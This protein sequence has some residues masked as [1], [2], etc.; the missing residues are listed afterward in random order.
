[1]V[2]LQEERA[3]HAEH[4]KHMAFPPDWREAALR[5]SGPDA[6]TVNGPKMEKREG[7]Q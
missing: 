6:R 3:P 2:D 1:M 4:R 7:D 5:G